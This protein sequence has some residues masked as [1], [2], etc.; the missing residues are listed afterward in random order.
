MRKKGFLLSVPQEKNEAP[1]VFFTSIDL[2]AHIEQNC[3]GKTVIVSCTDVVIPD[4]LEPESTNSH[5][6]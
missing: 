3:H 2:C 5:E 1:L 4:S 6:D